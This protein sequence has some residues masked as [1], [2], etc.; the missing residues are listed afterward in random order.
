MLF[1]K[2]TPREAF[3]GIC[4][5]MAGVDGFVDPREMIKIDEILT[6][7]GFTDQEVDKVFKTLSKMNPK[8]AFDWGAKAM[9]AIIDLDFQMK[10]NL[11]IA[12]KEIAEA[13]ENIDDMEVTLFRSVEAVLNL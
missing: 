10:R 6:R 13:D 5:S 1:K 12:L 3:I 8:K 7:Y 9:S 2:I 11:L 4:L